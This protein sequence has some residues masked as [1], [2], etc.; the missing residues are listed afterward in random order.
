MVERMVPSVSERVPPVTRL[1]TLRDAGRT[2]E[3]RA[4]AAGERE[5]PEAVEQV[6]AGAAAEVGADREVRAGEPAAG[7]DGSVGEDLRGGACRHGE[8]GDGDQRS[9]HHGDALRPG[10]SHGYLEN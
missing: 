4:L 2:A 6:A 1:I 5:V 7:A 3:R 8:R 9:C 10:F